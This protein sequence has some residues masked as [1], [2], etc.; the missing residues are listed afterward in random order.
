MHSKKFF[1]FLWIRSAF[2]KKKEE[3]RQG[4]AKL[5]RG[6]KK[7]TLNGE[8]EKK[9]E[10]DSKNEWKLMKGSNKRLGRN[11]KIWFRERI[12]VKWGF[13]RWMKNEIDAAR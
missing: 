7:K 1:F 8:R 6:N 9:W 2:R 10:K 5:K 13:F 11:Y 4:G 3:N 12:K